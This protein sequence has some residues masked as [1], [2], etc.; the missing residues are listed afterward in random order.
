MGGAAVLAADRA[1]RLQR[2]LTLSGGPAG[3]QSL[4]THRTLIITA[5]V[6]IPTLTGCRAPTAPPAARA[7]DVDP[8]LAEPIYWYHQPATASITHHDFDE[9]WRAA[10]DAARAKMFTLDR[11]DYRSGILTTEPLVSSQFFE[12]WRRD[13]ATAYDTTESSLATIRRTVRYEFTRNDDATFTVTPKVLVERRTVAEQRITSVV[14]VRGAFRR[15]QGRSEHRPY[16][17]PEADV[18][19]YLPAR[20]W[21]ALRRDEALEAELAESIADRIAR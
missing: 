21:Y 12:P 4:M 13:T 10:E 11:R 19:V 8:E 3:P 6:L 9:L 17:T 14:M 1:H 15:F 2:P 7:I 20:Y 5:L 16:G 18:G